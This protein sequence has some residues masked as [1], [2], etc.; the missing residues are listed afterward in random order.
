MDEAIVLAEQ[1]IGQVEPNPPVGA[2]VVRD[3]QVVGRGS[4]PFYGGP[5]AEVLALES[6][7]AGARGGTLVVTLEPCSSSGKT[8]PCTGLVERSGVARVVV[9][10]VDPDPRH[11]G[12]GLEFLRERGVEV[13]GPVAEHRTEH[14][15]RRFRRHLALRRPFLICK[16]AMTL[17][18]KLATRTG[19]S[20]WISGEASRAIVHELRGRVDGILVGAGT[21]ARDRPSL[22]ARPEG[23]LRALRIILDRGLRTPP[24]WPA[25]CDG[26]PPILLF[27]E[28]AASTS[29][30]TR[31]NQAG[32]RTVSAEAGDRF[33]IS[34]LEQ[35]HAQGTKRVLVE[36]GARILGLLNDQRL[37]DQVLV[38]V[39]PR[40][41]GGALAPS[42]LAGLGIERAD[43]GSGFEAASW[44]IIGQDAVF[45]A[46]VRAP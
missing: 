37:I 18:G 26:G 15:L 2:L 31:L 7:G 6:A 25:L 27:H 40:L 11:A 21:V 44:R 43:D 41:F 29:R 38:F 24:D 35:L 32:A 13:V 12:A 17:D 14:L 46:L 39:G 34:V 1:G 4:H 8:P 16:W 9:G 10:A 22:T 45:Q 36:G 5:H 3:G 28:P 30:K 20:R 33:L 42:P 23:P 19:E